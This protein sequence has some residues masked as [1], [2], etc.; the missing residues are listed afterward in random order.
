MSSSSSLAQEELEPTAFESVLAL[1]ALTP[2]ALQSLAL[3]WQDAKSLLMNFAPFDV[4]SD[5]MEE[6]FQKSLDNALSGLN[7]VLSE[8]LDESQTR[9]VV[10]LTR[11]KIMDDIQRLLV[12]IGAAVDESYGEQLESMRANQ[13]DLVNVLRDELITTEEGK[14]DSDGKVKEM[15]DALHKA[16][17]NVDRMADATSRLN[18]E[19]EEQ[20]RI[21]HSLR[22]QLRSFKEAVGAPPPKDRSRKSYAGVSTR[23]ALERGHVLYDKPAAF[24]YT[25]APSEAGTAHGQG[26]PLTAS[27]LESH[28]RHLQATGGGGHRADGSGMGPAT[29]T[30]GGGASVITS[31]TIAAAATAAASSS[32]ATR[33]DSSL[34]WLKRFRIEVQ[35]REDSNIANKKILTFNNC[36]ATIKHIYSEK[37]KFEAKVANVKAQNAA[38]KESVSGRGG[39]SGKG[40]SFAN[41]AANTVYPA[42]ETLERFVYRML[43]K[44]F[45]YRKLSVDHAATLMAS[46]YE[47]GPRD[48]NV[49]IFRATF[50]REVDESF[51]SVVVALK[52]S[53]ECLVM[54]KIQAAEPN[55]R[56]EHYKSRFKEKSGFGR[57]A[58]EEWTEIVDY[59]YDVNDAKDLARRVLETSVQADLDA[60]KLTDAEAF[61]RLRPAE[62][63][64]QEPDH[65]GRL[66]YRRRPAAHGTLK[67][68]HTQE[69]KYSTLMNLCCLFQLEKRI[70]AMHPVRNLFDSFDRDNDGILSRR[71]F[72]AFVRE[73]GLMVTNP[74]DEVEVYNKSASAKHRRKKMDAGVGVG[75]KKKAAAYATETVFLFTDEQEQEATG[76]MTL[77]ASQPLAADELSAKVTKRVNA[78][79]PFRVD[80]ITFTTTVA[81]YVQIVPDVI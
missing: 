9:I 21:I 53:I 26:V 73:L 68:P 19:A 57:L 31:P 41:T 23:T 1:N 55:R 42:Q 35:A 5:A 61:E 38:R 14:A 2:E 60:G 16:E 67:A 58:H 6:E 72:A 69:V 52:E 46:L 20:N 29:A 78:A 45:G 75:G 81:H 66:G 47:Y 24:S 80:R 74:T 13:S 7:T 65:K 77:G 54:A 63:T 17:D 15:Q 10:M 4:D 8:G 70:K 64:L 32:S 49:A 36:L 37:E 34:D 12:R 40:V 56:H 30:V 11:H 59:L 71:E 27:M 22:E 76:D 25:G 51:P 3:T 28:T 33:A 39:F 50:N 43:D 62:T 48:H 44:R 79:D 18:A